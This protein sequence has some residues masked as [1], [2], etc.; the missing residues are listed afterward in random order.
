MT[1]MRLLLFVLTAAACGETA[2]GD[3]WTRLE[4]SE[5]AG[6]TFADASGLGDMVFAV[7]DR[8]ASGAVVMTTSGS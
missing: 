1:R 5:V 6:V 2:A 4:V 3:G 7:G 8:G